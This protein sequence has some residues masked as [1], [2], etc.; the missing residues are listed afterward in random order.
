MPELKMP[1]VR[2][3]DFKLSGLREMSRDD[4]GRALSDVHLPEVDLSNLDPRRIDLSNVELPKI[5]V[6]KAVESAAV[7]THLR[8]RG[9]SPIRFVIGGVVVAGLALFAALNIP[10]LR[11]G[12]EGV[13]RTVR[14]QLDARRDANSPDAPGFPDDAFTGP[15]PSSP[16]A[17]TA[18]DPA[19]VQPDTYADA[20][21]SASHGFETTAEELPEGIGSNEVRSRRKS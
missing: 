8:K 6:S 20:L 17:F 10:A 1:E 2:M 16:E 5:D 21:P 15:D 7:A 19:P 4:I 11:A 14:A 9:S 12:L 3:P 13:A 18:A